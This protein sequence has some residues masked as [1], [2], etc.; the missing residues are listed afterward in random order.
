MPL[1]EVVGDRCRAGLV[2]GPVEFLA[3]RDDLIFDR[4]RGAVRAVPRPA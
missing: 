3:D 2:A 4:D 1:F